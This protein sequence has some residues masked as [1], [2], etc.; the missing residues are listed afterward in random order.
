V[1]LARN[2]KVYIA[3]RSQERAEQAIEDLKRET[4]KEGLYLHVDL[5][6]L[7]SVKAAAK[8]FLNKE[9]VLHVLFNNA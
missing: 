2:A 4:G 9:Q 1:L 8:E 7:A 5:A 6:D 3:A